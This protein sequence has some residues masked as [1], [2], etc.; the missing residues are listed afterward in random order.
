M[1][2]YFNVELSPLPLPGET[3]DWLFRIEV[4]ELSLF[5]RV[6]G[7]FGPA[8]GLVN[9][10]AWFT[11]RWA[12]INVSYSEARSYQEVPLEEVVISGN[13]SW[14]GDAT[15]N[16]IIELR[17]T[18]RLPREG[19]W[20]FEGCFTGE[21]WVNTLT[22]AKYIAVADGISMNSWG[23][24]VFQNTPVA[25]LG[26]FDYGTSGHIP[27]TEKYPVCLELDISKPPLSGEEVV[28]TSRVSSPYIDVEDCTGY[29]KFYKREK[30]NTYPRIPGSDLLV[31]G[32]LEWTLDVIKD[33]IRE[34]SAVIKFPEPGEWEIRV[35]GSYP[36]RPMSMG[37]FY[38]E[39]KFTITKDKA[40]YGWANLAIDKTISE[41]PGTDWRI[42]GIY[43]IGGLL[44]IG[45]AI[46]LILRKRQ[47]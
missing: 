27:P 13:T 43:V 40:Y 10:R 17:S 31:S 11:V 19:F 28:I 8:E 39:I 3:A 14:E 33:E 30:D 34:S 41:E 18:I 46:Y 1:P 44:V 26:L 2:I 35:S 36:A 47:I 4:K 45:I 38:D 23:H 9:S 12:G 24:N 6:R 22:P 7:F 16:R 15:V 20:I 21:N 42:I 37:G 25:Y 32:D 29:Y 5:E